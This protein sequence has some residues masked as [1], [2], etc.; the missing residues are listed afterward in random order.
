[1]PSLGSQKEVTLS[2]LASRSAFKTSEN[3]WALQTAE[4]WHSMVSTNWS[5]MKV[6]TFRSCPSCWVNSRTI[7]DDG[8]RGRSVSRRVDFVKD[9][10]MRLSFSSE[11]HIITYLGF[12]EPAVPSRLLLPLG[13][14]SDSAKL[15]WPLSVEDKANQKSIWSLMFYLIYVVVAILRLSP[16]SKAW[17]SLVWFFWIAWQVENLLSS[18]RAGSRLSSTDSI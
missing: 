11:V 9:W 14:L 3:A 4:N 1:M 18:S 13:F 2:A 10:A 7:V 16:Y 6:Y 15:E 5:L 8:W 17:Y 12:S